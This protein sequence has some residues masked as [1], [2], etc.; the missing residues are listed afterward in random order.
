MGLLT[1]Y[2]RDETFSDVESGILGDESI[3][4][5]GMEDLLEQNWK[6]LSR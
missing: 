2:L 3:E 1:A 4:F 6:E 5:S